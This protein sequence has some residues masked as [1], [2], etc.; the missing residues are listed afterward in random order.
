MSLWETRLGGCGRIAI[1]HVE[2]LVAEKFDVNVDVVVGFA[3]EGD[4]TIFEH[5][6]LEESIKDLNL[7]RFFIFC[8]I[9]ITN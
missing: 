9:K 3:A 7:N 1:E 6:Q 4:T 5:V 8:R 2:F